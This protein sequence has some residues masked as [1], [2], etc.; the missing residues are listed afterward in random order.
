M[1]IVCYS[2]GFLYAKPNKCDA[3]HCADNR[4]TY[5]VSECDSCPFQQNKINVISCLSQIVSV[6][7]YVTRLVYD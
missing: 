5:G 4:L 1:S 2:R 3:V 6:Q 7:S